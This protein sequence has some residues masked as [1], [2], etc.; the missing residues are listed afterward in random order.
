MATKN[1][2]TKDE[3]YLFAQGTLYK[4]WETFGAHIKNGGVEFTL[5]C[6]WVKSVSVC[7][8]FNDWNQ[9]EYW[10]E[11]SEA[12]GIWRTFVKSAEEDDSYKYVIEL[13]NG[14]R[15]YKA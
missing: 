5:W 9:D 2:I 10:M 7:G 3:L 1:T 15:I 4:A 8:S 6:P 14:E 12:G 11:P 13:E